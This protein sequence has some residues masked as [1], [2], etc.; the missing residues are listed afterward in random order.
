LTPETLTIEVL[1]SLEENRKE[2]AREVIAKRL[3]LKENTISTYLSQGEYLTDDVLNGLTELEASK[4]FFDKIRSVKTASVRNLREDGKSDADLSGIISSKILDWFQEF[5][6]CG[7]VTFNPI[8][9]QEDHE[10]TLAV[11]ATLQPLKNFQYKTDMG[12]EVNAEDLT[13]KNYCGEYNQTLGTLTDPLTPETLTIEVLESLEE[14]IRSDIEKLMNGLQ[15][16][17]KLQRQLG[18]Q[19]GS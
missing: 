9:S 18:V 16:I 14:N 13:I 5:Q 3:G 10:Q 19:K 17:N 4:R 11:E 15:L 8:V 12:N 1:E 2:N 6:S 7:K